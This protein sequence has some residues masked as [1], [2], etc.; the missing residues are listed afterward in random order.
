MA[1][2]DIALRLTIIGWSTQCVMVSQVQ[3]S[4]MSRSAVR[5]LESANQTLQLLDCHFLYACPILTSAGS[6]KPNTQQLTDERKIQLNKQGN[7]DKNMRQKRN[8]ACL[9]R[10]GMLLFDCECYPRSAGA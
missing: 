5:D 8:R 1:I 9:V 6:A 7:S 4:R 10:E 2:I 3:T